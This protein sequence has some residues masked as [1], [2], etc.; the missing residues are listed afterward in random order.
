M[1]GV[2]NI[3]HGLPVL[4]PEPTHTWQLLPVDQSLSPAQVRPLSGQL[5][6][7]RDLKGVRP[8]GTV[9]PLMMR[10]IMETVQKMKKAIEPRTYFFSTF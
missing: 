8:D 4:P 1:G 5:P 7:A 2:Q 3:D 10:S 6:P 9:D